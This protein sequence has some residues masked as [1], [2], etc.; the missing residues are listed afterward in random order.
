MVEYNNNSRIESV[1][2]EYKKRQKQLNNHH[3]FHIKIHTHAHGLTHQFTLD[4]NTEASET[5]SIYHQKYKRVGK[6]TRWWSSIHIVCRLWA[7]VHSNSHSFLLSILMYY[8]LFS[9]FNWNVHIWPAQYT[10]HV[11]HMFVCLFFTLLCNTNNNNNQ[12]HYVCAVRFVHICSNRCHVPANDEAKKSL[13]CVCT[14]SENAF[15]FE[16]TMSLCHI[17]MTFLIS[18]LGSLTLSAFCIC[19]IHALVYIFPQKQM[20]MSFV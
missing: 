16:F 12:R 15:V 19:L 17:R 9:I 8:S 3:L 4:R 1:Y 2:A 11:F 6:Y 10:K 5:E 14:W 18:G 13:A 20:R 7:N